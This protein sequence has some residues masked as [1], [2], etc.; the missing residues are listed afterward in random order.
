MNEYIAKAV[1]IKYGFNPY[2]ASAKDL[3]RVEEVIA[4]DVTGISDSAEWD[5]SAFPNLRKIDCSF[6]GIKKLNV[7]NN[8]L[9][10]EIRWEGVRGTLTTIDFSKNRHLRKIR[11]GQD[12]MVEL[13]LSFNTEL[14]EIE[15]WLN[16]YM[17]WINIDNC[18]NLKRIIMTGVNI[19]FVDLTHCNSLELVDINYMNL[20]ARKRDEYGPG[21]PRPIIF[22][23]HDFNEQIIPQAARNDKYFKYYLVKTA[24]DSPENKILLDLKADKQRILNI[25][26]DRYGDGVAY[27][28]YDILSKLQ[29]CQQIDNQHQKVFTD[30][31]LSF[32]NSCI[33]CIEAIYTTSIH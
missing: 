21:Y 23:Q 2:N 22:V 4:S 31:D 14:E 12:G 32:L 15:I 20:Y 6:N 27:E 3:E 28:H 13:D 16:R 5:F 24:S 19:P 29:E 7:S 17:R 10:E 1:E 30:D 33:C 11:G 26:A 25:Y 8:L 9:L 18:I